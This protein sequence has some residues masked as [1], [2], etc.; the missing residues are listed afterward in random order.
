MAL[1]RSSWNISVMDLYFQPFEWNYFPL[2]NGRIVLSN[3]KKKKF[4]K[5]FSSFFFKAFSKKKG[6]WQ[7]LYV[8]MYVC[9][10]QYNY[11]LHPRR[12]SYSNQ[13]R[14]QIFSPLRV[15]ICWPRY[16]MQNVILYSALLLRLFY[17]QAVYPLQQNQ[18]AIL[19]SGQ[20]KHAKTKIE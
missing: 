6:F 5:I 13:N 2:L 8:H 14:L 1:H 7:T 15:H 3:K 19:K 17:H 11:Y 9:T 18:W 12:Y 20:P 10:I 4:K 16:D